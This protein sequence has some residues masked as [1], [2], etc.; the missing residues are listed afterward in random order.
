MRHSLRTK[1]GQPKTSKTKIRPQNEKEQDALIKICRSQ[2]QIGM[3]RRVCHDW[4]SERIILKEG[5]IV[6]VKEHR[7]DGLW[8]VLMKLPL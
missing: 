8:F 5:D 2:S 7:A 3:L 4:Q 1:Y 6:W